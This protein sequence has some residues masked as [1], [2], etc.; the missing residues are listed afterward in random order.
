M[1]CTFL[2]CSHH[3]T[4]VPSCQ[5]DNREMKSYAR[6]ILVLGSALA[7]AVVATRLHVRGHLAVR[8]PGFEL[9]HVLL[10]H[11]PWFTAAI[12]LWALLSVYWEIAASEASRATSSEST[13]SRALHVSLTNIGIILVLAPLHGM[14]RLWPASVP[15]MAAGLIIEAFGAALAIWARWVL[16]RNWSGRIAINQ[17]HKLIRTGPYRFFRHPI[18]TGFLIMTVGAALVTGERLAVAG[19]ILVGFAYWR[20][21]RLEETKL[22][23]AFGSEY[24]DYRR[25]S[26]GLLPGIL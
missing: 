11:L 3:V 13:R 17:G 5:S 23:L 21:V 22:C 19:L 8:L 4:K 26:W 25:E 16:G 6:I 7:G 9:D 20:K 15:V 2:N 14:G 24:E 1:M 12:V 18:Y 10:R